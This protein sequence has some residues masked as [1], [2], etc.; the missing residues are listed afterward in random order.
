MDTNDR[1]N[2]LADEL[3]QA[4]NP[5]VRD[6]IARWRADTEELAALIAAGSEPEEP[7][8]KRPPVVSPDGF[9]KVFWDPAEA[10]KEAARLRDVIARD[11]AKED[12]LAKVKRRKKEES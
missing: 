11:I 3:E 12:A 2:E 8:E 9:T 4:D 6:L 1:A 5:E 7:K 10:Q